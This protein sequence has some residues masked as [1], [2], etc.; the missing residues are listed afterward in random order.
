MQMKYITTLFAVLVLTAGCKKKLTPTELLAG[1]T[2]K[3]WKRYQYQTG[4]NTPMLLDD[5]FSDDIW[6]FLNDGNLQIDLSGTN[7][8]GFPVPGNIINGV[9]SFNSTNDTLTWQYNNTSTVNAFKIVT[10][11]KDELVV[12][13][14]VDSVGN[15]NTPNSNI[16]MYNYFL[17]R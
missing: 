5:C 9:W 17:A 14:R 3:K 15:T 13:Q 12:H 8:N 6:T 2:T 7:C 1:E 16:D 10:L 11:S 4:T